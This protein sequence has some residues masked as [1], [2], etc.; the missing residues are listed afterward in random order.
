[1][2][3]GVFGLYNWF[4]CWYRSREIGTSSIDW[5][6]L[7][8]FYLKMETESSLWNVV[9]WN[10]NRTVFLDKFGTMDNVHKCSIC[11]N[12]TSSQT[13]ISYLLFITLCTRTQYIISVPT[14]YQFM[15]NSI[16]N[17]RWSLW[18]GNKSCNSGRAWNQEPHRKLHWE[19]FM[20]IY[21]YILSYE[22]LISWRQTRGL[23][24]NDDLGKNVK[25][26]DSDLTWGTVSAC[27]WRNWEPRKISVKIVS[28]PRFKLWI[29]RIRS[30]GSNHLTIMFGR[31]AVW[32]V[33]YKP[34]WNYKLSVQQ[35]IFQFYATVPP[36]LSLAAP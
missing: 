27:D 24:V 18:R 13:F 7:S 17:W 12:I 6:Q 4:R 28:R 14:V 25:E 8:R 26:I 20:Y 23:L 30:R 16:Q 35:A 32:I 1:M 36:S 19:L 22:N 31:N 5:V 15:C 11:T 9:F 34:W 2:V 29:P 33:S 21:K 3:L 10:I